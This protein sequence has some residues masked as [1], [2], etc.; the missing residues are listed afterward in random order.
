MINAYHLEQRQTLDLIRRHLARVPG[1]RDRLL[2][3]IRPYRA[4]REEV[5]GF[6]VRHFQDLCTEKCFRSRLSACCSREGII[7]FFADTA[8]NVLISDEAA[9]DELA[10]VLDRPN[11]G[12]KCVYL[13]DGGCL[14]RIK[15]IVCEMFLCD[16]ALSAAFDG[17]PAAADAWASLKEKRKGFTWP[18]R[19]VIFDELEAHFMAAGH[20]SPLMY[21]H[22]SPGLL[23]VKQKAGLPVPARGT[24]EG[25]TIHERR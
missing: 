25:N 10:A 11:E 16:A 18:D 9:L 12:V 20:T 1:D 5:A 4:F 3:R 24:K 22:N 21:L 13:G 19:P 14:W 2:E 17:D 7:T 6:L 15:P 23:R 8:V